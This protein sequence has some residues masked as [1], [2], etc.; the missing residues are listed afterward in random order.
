MVDP[1]CLAAFD[2]VMTPADTR[3]SWS[4]ICAKPLRA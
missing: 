3:I 1:T 4:C 2:A